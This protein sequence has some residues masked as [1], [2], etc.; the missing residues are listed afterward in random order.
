MRIFGL[1]CASVLVLSI[2]AARLQADGTALNLDRPASR[3]AIAGLLSYPKDVRDAALELSQYPDLVIQLRY[4]GDPAAMD[5]LIAHYPATA[6]SA[7]RVIAGQ[8][9]ALATVQR[10]LLSLSTLGKTY[11]TQPDAVRAIVDRMSEQTHQETHMSTK[12]WGKRLEKNPAA[13][14]EFLNVGDELAKTKGTANFT[15]TDLPTPDQVD[16]TLVH[17]DRFPALAGEIIDQWENEKN[18]EQFRQSVD[19]WYAQRRDSLPEHFGS[20]AAFRTKVLKEQVL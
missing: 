5:K 6:Q 14:Q 1:G 17:S 11:A 10:H 20:D 9:D 2:G 12:Q 13:A 15:K 7:A 18:P 16:Y 8:G 4:S 3:M 19:L